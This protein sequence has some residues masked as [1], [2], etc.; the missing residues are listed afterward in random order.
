[1]TVM[2]VEFLEFSAHC[3]R[4][5]QAMML[6]RSIPEHGPLPELLVFQCPACDEGEA[7]EEKRAA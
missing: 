6:V 2:T 3:P 1:M 5:E 7:T 4:C